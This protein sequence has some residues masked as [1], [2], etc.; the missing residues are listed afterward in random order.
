MR[1]EGDQTYSL[2]KITKTLI[3]DDRKRNDTS[4]D[5]KINKVD[6]LSKMLFMSIAWTSSAKTKP[7]ERLS[8][9]LLVVKKGKKAIEFNKDEGKR[10]RT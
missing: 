1:S 6:T 4:T 7:H 9:S 5:S 3:L 2:S 10:G 8:Q